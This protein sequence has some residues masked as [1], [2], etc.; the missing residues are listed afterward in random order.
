MRLTHSTPAAQPPGPALELPLALEAFCTLHRPRYR[1]YIRAH[2]NH[3][4]A[5]EAVLREAL[6]HL[7]THWSAILGEPNPAAH[8][9]HHLTDHIHTRTPRLPLPI[10]TRPEYDVLVLYQVTHG[11]LPAIAET[12]GQDISKI[13]Y[14]LSSWTGR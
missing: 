12:T 4:A 8:A 13:R 3:P 7:V 9:W 11:C 5:A 6:G 2:I 10:R 1:A 14:I